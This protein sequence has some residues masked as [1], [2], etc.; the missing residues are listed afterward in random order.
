MIGRAHGIDGNPVTKNGSEALLH[1]KTL[2]KDRFRCGLESM[3]GRAHRI[4]G[5]PVTKNGSVALLLEEM[6]RKGQFGAVWETYLVVR[7]WFER[8]DWFFQK[9]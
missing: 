4:D 8:P 6:L 9:I 7:V 3:I 1:V 2:G 5:N